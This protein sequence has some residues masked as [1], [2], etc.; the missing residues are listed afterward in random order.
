[1]KL[2]ELPA[3]CVPSRV[4]A[5]SV[6]LIDA[7]DDRFPEPLYAIS[8][9]RLCEQGSPVK[10]RLPLQMLR[11]ITGAE[12]LAGPRGLIVHTGRCGSTLLANMLGIH[13]A[14]RMIKEPDAL[15]QILL[16]RAPASAVA[17]I[18]R[19]FG[20]G[21]PAASAVLV[22]CTNWQTLELGR[23]LAELKQARAIFLWRPAEEVV[24][25][26]LDQPA[27]WQSWRYDPERRDTW[28]PREPAYPLDF[29]DLAVLYAHAWR[30]SAIA[31]LRARQEF[32]D[33]VKIISYAELREDPG[34]IVRASAQHFG[35]TAT[36]ELT[37]R[38]TRHAAGYSK[39]PDV[40]FDPSGIHARQQLTA[41]QRRVVSRIAGPL[42]AELDLARRS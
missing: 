30:V 38:M 17:A 37:A 11:A 36:P 29:A 20:R 14:V 19:A 15:S 4:L 22:K 6:Y 40:P 27:L 31:A 16:D 18:L 41:A 2:T 24:A 9:A 1:M 26:Y 34:E 13:P 42:E 35:L 33:R 39:S 3:N 10:L 7:G 5:D 12:A 8:L 28:F 25:S 23:L 21:L 32:A